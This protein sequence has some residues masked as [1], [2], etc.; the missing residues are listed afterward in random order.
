LLEITHRVIA[1]NGIHMHLAE[2]GEG[3]LVVLLAR[4]RDL[5]TARRALGP[6]AFAAAWETGA[7]LPLAAAVAEALAD[8]PSPAF[9]A[10]GA[11]TASDPAAALG[12]TARE[13]DVLRLLAQG[14]SN[15]EIGNALFISRRTVNFH[16]TNL[17]GKLALQSY[18]A[19]AA[20]AVR[21]G[22]A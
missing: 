8:D 6:A 12:L 22:L 18:A 5:A 16:V 1:T 9:A 19:A 15:R 10:S 11:A 13:A 4:E 20:F 7:A 2:A 21:H 17:L 3:R 14:R